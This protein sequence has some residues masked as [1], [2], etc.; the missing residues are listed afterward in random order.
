[1]KNCHIKLFRSFFKNSSSANICGESNTND[2]SG[3]SSDNNDALLFELWNNPSGITVFDS[4][5]AYISFA[6]RL[7]KNEYSKQLRL[8]VLKT[9]VAALFIFSLSIPFA[10]FYFN[11]TDKVE[12]INYLEYYSENGIVKEI[13]LPDSSRVTLNSGSVLIISSLYGKTSRD[14]YLSGEGTFKVRPNRAVPFI[15]TTKTTVTKA[16]GTEFNVSAYP[17]CRLTSS[18]LISGSVVVSNRS[19]QPNSIVLR[20]GQQYV[21]DN[22]STESYVGNVSVEEVTDWINGNLVFR[23]QTIREILSVLERNYKISFYF[24]PNWSNDDVFNFRFRK[25]M[26]IDSILSII[27]EVSASFDYRVSAEGVCLIFPLE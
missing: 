22:T 17:D 12:E 19:S 9:A 1:M 27:K 3:A 2:N 20:P 24:D 23:S 14:I 10:Y 25:E 18:T 15:V 4:Q 11:N 13:I 7:G 21:F 5:E 8:R 26:G 16:L 6:S